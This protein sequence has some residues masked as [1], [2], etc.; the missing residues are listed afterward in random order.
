MGVTGVGVTG[1]GVTG[2]GV[3]GVGVTG[4]SGN[5]TMIGNEIA[6][7]AGLENQVTPSWTKAKS[8]LL[9]LTQ[10]ASPAVR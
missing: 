8:I 4:V 5:V 9:G 3:T 6:P 10:L 7:F 1:V 2:V